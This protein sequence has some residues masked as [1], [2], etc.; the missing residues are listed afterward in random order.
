MAT[1]YDNQELVRAAV[2][3]YRDARLLLKRIQ[4]SD[5]ANQDMAV[6]IFYDSLD[7][8]LSNLEEAAESFNWREHMHEEVRHGDKDPEHALIKLMQGLQ[9]GSVVKGGPR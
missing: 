2:N 7:A 6:G 9:S 1:N 3:T 4:G 5:Q 8:S